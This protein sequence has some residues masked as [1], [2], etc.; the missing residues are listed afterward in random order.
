M[1]LPPLLRIFANPMPDKKII[2]II[3]ILSSRPKLPLMTY[4]KLHIRFR[5]TP[6]WPWMTF[7]SCKFKFSANFAETT[8]KRMKIYLYFQQQH[9]NPLDVLF[10]VDVLFNLMFLAFIWGL[11]CAYQYL[12]LAGLSCSCVFPLW[13][14]NFLSSLVHICRDFVNF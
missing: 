8:A 5:L 1:S 7:N 10:N 9:C 11:S 2:N 3:Y 4:R 14:S 13:H 12:A 6:R